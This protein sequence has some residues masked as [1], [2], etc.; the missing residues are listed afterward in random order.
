MFSFICFFLTEGSIYTYIGELIELP[1]FLIYL[2]TFCLFLRL[3]Y[4][5]LP[6]QLL[7]DAF[8]PRRLWTSRSW[9]VL[10]AEPYGGHGLALACLLPASNVP[11]LFLFCVLP[12][13]KLYELFDFYSGL[14]LFNIFIFS[15][16]DL[17][18]EMCLL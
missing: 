13:I 8:V 4:K 15:V 1:W 6:P 14:S 7:I 18:F 9:I 3:V 17:L 5:H 10:S 12:Q 16:S 11:F 2:L